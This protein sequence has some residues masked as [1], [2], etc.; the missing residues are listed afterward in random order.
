MLAGQAADPAGALRVQRQVLVPELLVAFAGDPVQAVT[1]AV[2]EGAPQRRLAGRR[3]Q[4]QRFGGGA[5]AGQV[6]QGR[7]YHVLAKIVGG[8]THDGLAQGGSAG[9]GSLAASIPMA[10][11]IADLAA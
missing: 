8:N 7:A 4:Q 11:P 6:V 2:V 5:V 3:A 1:T 10:P 9:P